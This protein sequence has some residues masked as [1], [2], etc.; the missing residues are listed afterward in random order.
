MIDTNVLIYITVNPN[1]WY[2][3]ARQWLDRMFNEGFEL[4]IST[5]IAREYL[6]VLTRGDIFEQQFTSEEAI[7]EL[8]AILSVF[9][10][11][12]E[13]ERSVPFLT[14][15]LQRY[16]VRGKSIHDANIVATMLVHGVKRLATYNSVDFRRFREITLESAP[17]S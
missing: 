10:L 9:T 15:L 6:V 2:N 14:D 3:A 16:Q 1:P 8:N 13:N 11:L 7:Y 12:D 4:C 17:A 5:Q